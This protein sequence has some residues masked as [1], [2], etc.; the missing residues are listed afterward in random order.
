MIYAAII[1]LIAAVVYCHK[2]D[3]KENRV[4]GRINH[5]KALKPKILAC[6]PAVLLFTLHKT[7]W[8][9]LM[10]QATLWGSSKSV[11]LTA[12]WF[13]F[14]FNS[15]WGWRVQRDPFYRSTAVGKNLS[16]FD[17]LVLHWP[18]G[19]YIFFILALISVATIFY[20]F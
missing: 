6:I 11:L 1:S 18:K 20:L 12:A 2:R 10:D 17:Q 15:F 8:P 9:L 14:L 7:G 13:L 5:S 19:L 4:T 3:W 16:R